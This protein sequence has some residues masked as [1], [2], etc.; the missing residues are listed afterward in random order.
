LIYLK[1]PTE[2]RC[3]LVIRQGTRAMRPWMM[4]ALTWTLTGIGLLVV[5]S[6][7]Q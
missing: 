5:I 7:L 2:A 3:N 1:Q 6:M 4:H